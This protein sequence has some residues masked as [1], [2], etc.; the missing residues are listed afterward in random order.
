MR[1]TAVGLAVLSLV[2][3]GCQGETQQS[4][5]EAQAQAAGGSGELYFSYPGDGQNSVPVSAPVFM[6]F[7]GVID[8]PIADM[9]QGQVAEFLRLEQVNGDGETIAIEN[10]QL[11]DDGSF[12]QPQPGR[13]VL[14]GGEV[15]AAMADLD[16][17][18]LVILA[19]Q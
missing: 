7:G 1:R 9:E 13:L 4:E 5:V 17:Q 18:A 15:V 3:A 19:A 11:V 10:V 6:R 12:R 14:A 16:D 8:T 2:L